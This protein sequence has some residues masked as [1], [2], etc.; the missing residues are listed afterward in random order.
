MYVL[1]LGFKEY[2]KEN[3]EIIHNI[4]TCFECLV[5]YQKYYLKSQE[6]NSLRIEIDSKRLLN[7]LNFI[8]QNSNP[9][10]VKTRILFVYLFR[11]LYQT[12]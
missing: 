9:Q 10:N 7:S 2:L 6:S 11:C 4:N 3:Q 5:K 8:L 1:N 12:S